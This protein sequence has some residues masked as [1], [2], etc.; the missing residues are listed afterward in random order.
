[1]KKLAD[2]SPKNIRGINT[3]PQN[4]TKYDFN[5]HGNLKLQSDSDFLA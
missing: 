4:E 5:K 3:L 2:N 1:M